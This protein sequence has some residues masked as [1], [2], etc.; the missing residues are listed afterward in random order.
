MSGSLNPYFVDRPFGYYYSYSKNSFDS[1]DHLS[2]FNGYPTNI[3]QNINKYTIT[4]PAQFSGSFSFFLGK[5]G[6]LTADVDYIP[7]KMLRVSGSNISATIND[8]IQ[9]TYKNVLNYKVGIEARVNIIRIRLG[10]NYLADPYQVTDVD[11][12]RY[13]FTGGFG[14]RMDNFYFDVAGVYST[15]KSGYT[16][17]TLFETPV[18][19]GVIHTTYPQSNSTNISPS[20]SINNIPASLLFTFGFRFD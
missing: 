17:Y 10:A 12:S 16:P 14:M 5:L 20:A 15:Y 1:T 18:N 6:F 11:R 8:E 9:D 7:Y 4:T 19:G 3:A 13:N 2:D